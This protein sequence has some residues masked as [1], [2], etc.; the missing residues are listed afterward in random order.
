MTVNHLSAQEILDISGKPM[1]VLGGEFTYMRHVSQ[2]IVTEYTWRNDEP[3]M[4]LFKDGKATRQG[5]YLIE[6]KDAYRYADSNGHMSADLFKHSIEAAIALGFDRN[7]RYAVRKIMDTIL[8][9]L[10][11][12]LSMPP[13]PVELE[14]AESIGQGNNEL[15]FKI[16]GKT[17][18]EGLV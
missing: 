12:L 7:D 14:K 13:V 18:F 10:P 6:L 11:D 8:D 1:V 9:G 3:V 17:M 2:G 4:I 16:D 15:S 5:A